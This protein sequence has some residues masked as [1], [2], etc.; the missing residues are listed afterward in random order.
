MKHWSLLWYC[1]CSVLFCP[2]MLKTFCVVVPVFLLF[3]LNK[4]SRK[5][6]LK[7]CFLQVLFFY[8]CRVTSYLSLHVQFPVLKDSK[9]IK[10]TAHYNISHHGHVYNLTCKRVSR[11]IR[12]CICGISIYVHDCTCL[13][14][15][16][17]G[18][19]L[20]GRKR[21]INFIRLPC[22]LCTFYKINYV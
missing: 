11:R 12:K 10:L 14:A 17:L 4:N 1:H 13:A 19:L 7:P 8:S 5:N 6:L 18:V 20:S 15:A 9:Y 3:S 22:T 2:L 16:V 21:N